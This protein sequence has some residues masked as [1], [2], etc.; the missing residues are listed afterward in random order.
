MAVHWNVEHGNWYEQVERALID[1]PQLRGADV[2]LFNEIDLGMARAANRDVTADLAAA[3]GLHAIWAPLF[4]ET[5]TGR[6]DDPRMAGT[7]AN[8][9]SL[10][11]LAI[12]SRWPIGDV[13]VLDLP[14]PMEIQFDLERMYGRHIAL[15][16]E[17]RRPGGPFVAVS[18]HLEVHRTRAD[19]ARQM[20]VL[21]EALR[22]ETRPVLLAGDFNSHTFDRGRWWD[23]LF[24]AAVLLGSPTAMVRR[25]LLYPDRGAGRERL[26]DALREANFEWNRFVDRAPTLQLRFD[27][28]DEARGLVQVFGPLWR[29]ILGSAERR[30]NLRLDWF[31]GRGWREGRGCT[32]RDLNGPGKASDHAPIVGFFQS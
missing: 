1:H 31:A 24:G 18:V 29:A 12:L 25:R 19:R 9:E 22:S 6:D 8:Q 13:Q 14:S 26:F 4:L 27:R 10:F 17:I 11:G 30:A 28:L 32:I 20:Q 7:L 3:L 15:L 23:P 21:M 2:L 5:T 16:A